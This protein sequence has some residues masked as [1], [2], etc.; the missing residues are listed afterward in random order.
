MS[1]RPRHR[2]EPFTKSEKLLWLALVALTVL[3][4]GLTL[5]AL[6]SWL[7]GLFQWR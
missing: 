4:L 2:D 5:W 7:S 6:Y 3:G 1:Y